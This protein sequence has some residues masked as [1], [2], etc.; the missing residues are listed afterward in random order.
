MEP[1]AQLFAFPHAGVSGMVRLCLCRAVVKLETPTPFI[2]SQAALHPLIS[3]CFWTLINTTLQVTQR[4][5]DL[6]VVDP[7]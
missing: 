7:E 4:Y 2:F 5:R 3:C 6:H 1:P